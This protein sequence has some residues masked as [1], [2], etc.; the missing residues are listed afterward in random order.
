MTLAKQ[1]T[2]CVY[3]DEDVVLVGVWAGSSTG[4][5]IEYETGRRRTVNL[6][7]L[8]LVDPEPIRRS[9]R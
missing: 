7:D 3:Q 9:Q 2:P 6:A 8:V 4:A 5:R 1:R